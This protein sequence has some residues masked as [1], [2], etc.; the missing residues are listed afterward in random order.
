[1]QMPLY[2]TASSIIML[3]CLLLGCASPWAPP[4]PEPQEL[5]ELRPKLAN[6]KEGMSEAATLKLLGLDVSKME[7]SGCLHEQH[8]TRFYERD[9]MLTIQFY[10]EGTNGLALGW[11]RLTTF[12]RRE[13]GWPK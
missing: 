6:L 9:Y 7:P 1:M 2:K 10:C 11:A 3:W 12:K 13:E 4:E 5:R 8:Y